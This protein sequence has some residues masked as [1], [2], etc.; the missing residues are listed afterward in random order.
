MKK[1]LKRKERIKKSIYMYACKC[2]VC[3]CVCYSPGMGRPLE[4][5]TKP[6]SSSQFIVAHGLYYS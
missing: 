3:T 5:T 4:Y 6:Y 2:S 1:S